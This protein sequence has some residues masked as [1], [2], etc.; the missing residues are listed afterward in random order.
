[1]D[2]AQFHRF[3]GSKLGLTVTLPL[4]VLG[5]YLLWNHTGHVFYALPYLIL[6]ACPL[7]HVFGHGHGHSHKPENEK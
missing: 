7:M 4:A 2:A 3:L 5:T 1:M 6:L